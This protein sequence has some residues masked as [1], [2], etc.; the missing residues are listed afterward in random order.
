ME[1]HSGLEKEQN[2]KSKVGEL[3]GRKRDNEFLE[4]NMNIFEWRPSG[5]DEMEMETSV[6]KISMQYS[7]KWSYYFSFVFNLLHL[8]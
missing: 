4:A 7:H 2:G 5:V 8:V 3:V 6:R 1:N